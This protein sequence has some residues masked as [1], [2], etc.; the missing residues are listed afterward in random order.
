MPVAHDE[1]ER[2]TDP[3]ERKPNG[4]CVHLVFVA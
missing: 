4:S 1:E 3:S 2:D